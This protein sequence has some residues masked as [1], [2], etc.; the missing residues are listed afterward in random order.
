[1]DRDTKLRHFEELARILS[2]ASDAVRVVK[3]MMMPADHG[4]QSL[5]IIARNIDG[6]I[7][8]LVTVHQDIQNIPVPAIPTGPLT[9]PRP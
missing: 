4:Y 8:Q 7:K 9:D 6:G 5:T 3:E 2:E 1:M